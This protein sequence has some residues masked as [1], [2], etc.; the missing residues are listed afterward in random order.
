MGSWTLLS[1]AC[2]YVT[3]LPPGAR[4]RGVTPRP[5]FVVRVPAVIGSITE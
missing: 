1:R 3:V 5:G 4:V 2:W